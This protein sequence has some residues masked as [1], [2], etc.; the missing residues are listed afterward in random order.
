MGSRF[1]T[2]RG[3]FPI[4]FVSTV[5]EFFATNSVQ[6]CLWILSQ[7]TDSRHITIQDSRFEGEKGTGTG[8]RIEG[9]STDLEITQNRFY[10]LDTALFIARPPHEKMIKGR[11]TSNTV[12]QAAAGVVLDITPLPP[13][14]PDVPP[15]PPMGRFELIFDRNY[16]A[17]TAE[18]GKGLGADGPVAGLTASH[19]AHGPGCG[20]GNLQFPVILLENP[21]LPSPN[22]KNDAN[23]SSLPERATRDRGEGRRSAMIRLQHFRK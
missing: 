6:I 16:F 5:F 8:I 9:E 2:Q 17:K 15:E 7:N 11:V 4:L 23:V 13:P 10:N 12:Y 14:L 3:H 18:I 21:E 19:N 20:T 22:E 1:S